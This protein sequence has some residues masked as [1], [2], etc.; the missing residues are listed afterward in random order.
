M[1]IGC[2]CPSSFLFPP[3]QVFFFFLVFLLFQEMS[4]VS[5]D[6][7]ESFSGVSCGPVLLPFFPP[8]LSFVLHLL[9]FSF[10]FARLANRRPFLILLVFHYRALR[11]ILFLVT[12]LFFFRISDRS[13]FFPPFFRFLSAVW[14]GNE[15]LE[16]AGF[17]LVLFPL[18]FPTP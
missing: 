4:K 17:C 14:V 5:P 6:K 1:T 7:N 12:C 2:N 9:F 15:H 16:S 8:R 18:F 10:S 11:F 3:W 13:S